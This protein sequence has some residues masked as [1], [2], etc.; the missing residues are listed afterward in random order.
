MPGSD[1]QRANV[2]ALRHLY[3]EWGRGNFS[4]RFEVYAPDFEWGWSDEFPG[5]SGVSRDPEARSSRLR[6]WLSPWEDWRCA[7]EDYVTSGQ[8]VVVLARY[9]GRGKESGA[10]VNTEGAHLWTMRDGKAIRLEIFSSRARALAA[11]GLT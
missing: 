5:M 1:V 7:A 4:P 6:E 2:E 9:S 8:L 10:A 3:D 11:A